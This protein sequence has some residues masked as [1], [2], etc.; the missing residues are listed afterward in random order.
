MKTAPEKL[1]NLQM[2][3]KIEEIMNSF[4]NRPKWDD[5]DNKVF[6]SLHEAWKALAETV[7]L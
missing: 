3:L 2:L 4:E 6:L 5:T 1:T 7:T